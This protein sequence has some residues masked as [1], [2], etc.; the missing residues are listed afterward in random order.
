MRKVNHFENQ[1]LRKICE[2]L[3]D[4]VR[5]GKY[6]SAKTRIFSYLAQ[7]NL[8]RRNDK[9]KYILTAHIFPFIWSLLTY[10]LKELYKT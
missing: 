4:S 9:F 6:K 10:P 8:I 3:V 1:A 2:N 5:M 7:C